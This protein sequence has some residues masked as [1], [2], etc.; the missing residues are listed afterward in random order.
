MRLKGKGKPVYCGR[1]GEIRHG[2]MSENEP[3]RPDG[4]PGE[5]SNGLTYAQAGVDI[6]AGNALVA[7]IKP[8]VK[9]TRRP[10]ADG[11]IGG[12][13]GLFDLKAA[14][15]NDPVLVAANVANK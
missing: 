11:E 3:S 7:A 10:G 14:G 6:D 15:F 5:K 2:F 8:A 1:T 12:F 9:S 13:G 4:Q